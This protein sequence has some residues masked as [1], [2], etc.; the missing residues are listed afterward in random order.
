[1]GEL[2]KVKSRGSYKKTWGCLSAIVTS[3]LILIVSEEKETRKNE[4]KRCYYIF[5]DSRKKV[6]LFQIDGLVFIAGAF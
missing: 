5:T 1:M 6:G 2:T 3:H 4:Q